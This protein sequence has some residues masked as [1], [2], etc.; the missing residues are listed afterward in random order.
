[1]DVEETRGCMREDQNVFWEVLGTCWE[2]KDMF[3]YGC[4]ASWVDKAVS[5]AE[6]A[7][8]VGQTSLR[9]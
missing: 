8:Q 6:D 2:N 7:R 4:W 9:C 5:L 3:R 1:M